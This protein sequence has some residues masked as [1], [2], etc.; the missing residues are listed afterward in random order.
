VLDESRGVPVPGDAGSE[1]D[2]NVG[3]TFT[4]RTPQAIVLL[5]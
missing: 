5:L 3:A 2:L 4:T 1:G